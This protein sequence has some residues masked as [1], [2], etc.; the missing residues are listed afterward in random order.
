MKRID[1]LKK[2]D[3]VVRKAFVNMSAGEDK[4]LQSR[5]KEQLLLVDEYTKKLLQA[6]QRFTNSLLAEMKVVPL[7]DGYIGQVADITKIVEMLI[8]D[9]EKLAEK[10]FKVAVNNSKKYLIRFQKFITE[11]DI[12]KDTLDFNR[13]FLQSSLFPDIIS[14]FE[15]AE[16]RVYKSVEATRDGYRKV[17]DALISRIGMYGGYIWTVGE[18]A[19]KENAPPGTVANWIG[20]SDERTCSGCNNAFGGN[21]YPIKQVPEP[22][23][24]AC[25]GRCRHAIQIIGGGYR[26]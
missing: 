11:A 24:F 17:S 5:R 10:Y 16:H 21:P 6:H 4:Q 15:N 7:Q 9:C 8:Q 23:S 22:G 13:Y 20:A 1:F 12:E 18:K 2:I 26:E 3:F 25:K 14:R 19:L